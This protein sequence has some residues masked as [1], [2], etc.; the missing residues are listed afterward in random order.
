MVVTLPSAVKDNNTCYVRI[1][2]PSESK[3]LGGEDRPYYISRDASAI[4]DLID[5]TGQPKPRGGYRGAKAPISRLD[6]RVKDMKQEIRRF[7]GQPW[8]GG[9]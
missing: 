4:G 6:G 2:L 5:Y 1:C 3:A 8:S 9:G 7:Q